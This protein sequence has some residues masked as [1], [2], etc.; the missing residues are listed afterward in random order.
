VTEGLGHAAAGLRALGHVVALPAD[1]PRARPSRQWWECRGAIREVPR[2][3]PLAA[4]GRILKAE[5]E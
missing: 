5:A 1:V 4:E 2:G 3:G